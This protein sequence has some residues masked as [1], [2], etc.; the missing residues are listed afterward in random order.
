LRADTRFVKADTLKLPA[1]DTYDLAILAFFV[2]VSDRKGNVDIPA[3][4]A[5]LAD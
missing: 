3:E 5:A 1:P 2:R 4:Q